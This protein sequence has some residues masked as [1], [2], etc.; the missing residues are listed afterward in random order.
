[1]SRRIREVIAERKLTVVT[2]SGVRQD[3]VVRLGKPKASAKSA[4][5]SCQVQVE[6]PGGKRNSRIFGLD[7]FQA[8][9]LALRYISSLT[10]LQGATSHS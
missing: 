7:A 4:D 9:E 10:P 6:G 8:L 1:M 3:I 2:E 5:F